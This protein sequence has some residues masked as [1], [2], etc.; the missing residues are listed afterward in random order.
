MKEDDL[1]GKKGKSEGSTK[2]FDNP[3]EILK[4]R[5]KNICNKNREKSR[6]LAQ[7]TRNAQVIEAA[8][9]KFPVDSYRLASASLLFEDNK[10]F[11]QAL[12]LAR[13]GVEYNPNN[14]D[15]WRVL[16]VISQSTPEEK[17]KAI[18]MMHKLD[19][20]NTDLK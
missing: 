19:P 13:K 7:Y 4:I 16:S 15:A 3:I 17:A 18:E 1:D 6:L 20:R 9:L 10:L 5:L 11:P 14:F 12:A 2:K 8:A